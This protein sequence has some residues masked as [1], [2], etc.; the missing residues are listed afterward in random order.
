MKANSNDVGTR[1]VQ[2]GLNFGANVIGNVNMRPRK[3]EQ[4]YQ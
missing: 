1:R 4:R 2:A 3:I